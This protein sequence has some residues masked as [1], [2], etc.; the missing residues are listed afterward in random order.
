MMTFANYSFSSDI[1][2]GAEN[3]DTNSILS[4]LDEIKSAFP[5]EY[6]RLKELFRQGNFDTVHQI[7]KHRKAVNQIKNLSPLL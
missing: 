5:E 3:T 4:E 2:A 7:I 6:N 1:P